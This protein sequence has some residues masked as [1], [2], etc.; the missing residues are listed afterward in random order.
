MPRWSSKLWLKF[1][2]L[3]SSTLL[4]KSGDNKVK[5]LHDCFNILLKTL[6]FISSQN[7][8]QHVNSGPRRTEINRFPVHSEP[9]YCVALVFESA[10]ASVHVTLWHAPPNE[11]SRPPTAIMSPLKSLSVQRASPQG[12]YPS[13]WQI[14]PLWSSDCKV[15]KSLVRGE[16]HEDVKSS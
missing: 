5:R 4:Q 7:K 1:E 3:C 12:L 16:T 8:T 13:A 11:P 10:G 9:P 6:S 14:N 2:M 15:W